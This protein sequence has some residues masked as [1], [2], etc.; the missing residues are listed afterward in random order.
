MLKELSIFNYLENVISA[1]FQNA[2]V[3]FF[4]FVSWLENTFNETL[5]TT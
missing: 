4:I 5:P 1:I 3:L 2:K